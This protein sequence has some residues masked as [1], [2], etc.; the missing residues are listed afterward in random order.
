MEFK[1]INYDLSKLF[2]NFNIDEIQGLMYK[3]IK[4]GKK[5]EEITDYI[6]GKFALTLPQDIIVNMEYNDFKNKNLYYY[7]KIL[8]LYSKGEHTN[9]TNF[10]KKINRNKN[11]VYTF[12]NCLEKINNIKNIKNEK[13]GLINEEHITNIKISSL[14]KENDLELLLD[15]FFN[16][17]MYKI[18][19]I[20]FTSYERY[21]MD[22]IR[23][24]I[25]YK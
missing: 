1:S 3:A 7:E 18:C 23:I 9:F 19:L 12:S 13:I 8:E 16:E 20:I 25:E 4:K 15:G 17:D 2:I 11:V 24:I 10:L 21:F 22:Y 6:L 5:V 14:N